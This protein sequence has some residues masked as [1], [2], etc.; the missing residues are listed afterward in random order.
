MPLVLIVLLAT[1][2]N[3]TCCGGAGSGSSS[4]GSGRRRTTRTAD[5]PEQKA[6]MTDFYEHYKRIYAAIEDR[7]GLGMLLEAKEDMA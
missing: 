5:S 6:E 3:L 7:R 4:E 1:V 2:S